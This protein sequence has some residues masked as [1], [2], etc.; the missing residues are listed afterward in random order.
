MRTFTLDLIRTVPNGPDP[1]RFVVLKCEERE[2]SAL[3][4]RFYKVAHI[5]DKADFSTAERA[6]VTGLQVIIQHDLI[7]A[8]MT[9]PEEDVPQ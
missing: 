9:R 1:P 2:G 3:V 5:I 8:G 6:V 4:K 7:A